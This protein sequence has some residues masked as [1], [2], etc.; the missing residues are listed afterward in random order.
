[1]TGA[2]DAPPQRSLSP[3]LVLGRAPGLLVREVDGE[4]VVFQPDGALFVLDPLASVVWG[5]LDGR[6][7]LATTY[8]ELATAFGE[9]PDRIATDVA[10]LLGPMLDAGLLVAAAG[11]G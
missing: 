7:P 2:G 4:T 9:T 1:M 5:L 10:A 6:T 11:S 3:D 8:A